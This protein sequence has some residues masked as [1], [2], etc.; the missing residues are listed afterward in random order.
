MRPALRFGT[1]RLPCVMR[2]SPFPRECGDPWIRR[3]CIMVESDAQIRKLADRLDS[4]RAQADAPGLAPGGL[5]PLEGPAGQES[6]IR[7]VSRVANGLVADDLD[8]GP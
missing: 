7:P 5:R 6:Y 8:L 4:G 2:G 1:V 3:E